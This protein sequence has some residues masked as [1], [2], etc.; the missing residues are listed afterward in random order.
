VQSRPILGVVAWNI[1]FHS[2]LT[3]TVGSEYEEVKGGIL[4][5]EPYNAL[6]FAVVMNFGTLRDF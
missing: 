3:A 5:R 1:W 6:V 4:A 2:R